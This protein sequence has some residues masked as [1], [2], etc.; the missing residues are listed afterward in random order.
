[1]IMSPFSFRMMKFLVRN[2][3]IL[4]FD[5]STSNFFLQLAYLDRLSNLDFLLVEKYRSKYSFDRTNEVEVKFDQK[6]EVR[7]ICHQTTEGQ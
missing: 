2:D 4:Y 6:V 3:Q 1:M 5:R 7:Y